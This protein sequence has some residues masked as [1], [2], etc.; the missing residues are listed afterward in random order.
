MSDYFDDEFEWDEAKSD[1]TFQRRGFDFFFACRVFEDADYLEQFDEIHSD[2][3]DRWKV[4]G[5]VEPLYLYVVY[6]QR[7]ARRR[8]L[9][10]RH[11]EP[12]EI[13]EYDRQF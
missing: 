11:C 4:M 10:A 6:T 8:I 9:H 13:D 3:E 5:W 1:S 2:D 7:G 12:G